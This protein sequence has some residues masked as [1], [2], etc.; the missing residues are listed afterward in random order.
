MDNVSY[1]DIRCSFQGNLLAETDARS[2]ES[3]EAAA[4]LPSTR[5]RGSY[6]GSLRWPFDR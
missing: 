3:E 6:G 2:R 1:M 4:T 5:Q